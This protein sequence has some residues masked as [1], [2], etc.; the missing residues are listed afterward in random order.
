M[1]RSSGSYISLPGLGPINIGRLSRRSTG[2]SGKC[3]DGGLN[4]D[5]F[6]EVKSQPTRKHWKVCKIS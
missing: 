5:L 4:L 2:D 3:L 1:P 6:P